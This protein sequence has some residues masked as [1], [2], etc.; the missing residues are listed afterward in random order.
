MSAGETNAR[1]VSN[2]RRANASS[3]HNIGVAAGAPGSLPA[4]NG[5]SKPRNRFDTRRVITPTGSKATV[6]PG[7]GPRCGTSVA[8]LGTAVADNLAGVTATVDVTGDDATRNVC[9]APVTG[10]VVSTFDPGVVSL[11]TAS[12][13]TVPFEGRWVVTSTVVSERDLPLASMT[14]GIAATVGAMLDPFDA[15]GSGVR[16]AVRVVV[17]VVT[18]IWAPPVLTATP[19]G[20]GVV[21]EAVDVDAMVDVDVEEAADVVEGV[22]AEPD[23]AVVGRA[24]DE[25]VDCD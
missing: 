11:G 22:E 7:A 15:A 21:F 3:D 19:A 4:A 20:A 13:V 9:L 17:G 5:F 25:L 8:A 23:V 10:A 24:V 1:T 18:L 6:A 16:G 14:G 12:D 2:S